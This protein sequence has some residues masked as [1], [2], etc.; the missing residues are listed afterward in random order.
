MANLTKKLPSG[1]SLEIQMG[2]WE[3]SVNL[4][5]VIFKEAESININLGIKSKSVE[6]FFTANLGDEAFD[7]LKN[8][9]ARLVSSQNIKTAMLPLMN[10][11]LYNGVR[12]T[13]PDVKANYEFRGDY[14]LI[15]KEVLV[16]NLTPFFKN[17]G[18]LLEGLP[19]RTISNQ[20]QL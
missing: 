1:A 4:M 18:S 5:E 14:F 6:E 10:K 3:E 9:I 17:L 13:N 8:I 7:T 16:Y 19:K 2:D 11:T 20:Q 12:C 15:L